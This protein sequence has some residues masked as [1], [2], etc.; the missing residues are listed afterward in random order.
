MKTS[1][2]FSALVLATLYTGTVSSSCGSSCPSGWHRI[3]DS[4]IWLSGDQKDFDSAQQQCAQLVHNGRL[5]EPKN[6]LQN[7]LVLTL[8]KSLQPSNWWIGITD[9]Q[10]EG[11]FEYLSSGKEPSFS[12]WYPGQP[13]DWRSGE[14]CVQFWFPGASKLGKWNDNAC[15]N[16][17]HYVCE[18]PLTT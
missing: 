15:K 9:R 7:D 3:L 17:R 6:R 10:S 18:K 8:L 5:F 2:T 14:D 16:S 12:N 1:L 11:R 13:D 4:C